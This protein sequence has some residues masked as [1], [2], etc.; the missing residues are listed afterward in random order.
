MVYVPMASSICGS[1]LR[2]A[3]CRLTG[4]EM[5]QKTSSSTASSSWKSS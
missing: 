3:D 2:L 4:I 1:F 5:I